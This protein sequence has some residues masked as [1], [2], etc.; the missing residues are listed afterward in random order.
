[1]QKA[2]KAHGYCKYEEEM[3][4]YLTYHS[5]ILKGHH[6]IKADGREKRTHKVWQERHDMSEQTNGDVKTQKPHRHLLT[7]TCNWQLSPRCALMWFLA[8]ACLYF[9]IPACLLGVTPTWTGSVV[10]G[11][12]VSALQTIFCLVKKLI[13][14]IL[15][16]KIEMQVPSTQSFIFCAGNTG[17][18]WR[19]LPAM[20]KKKSSRSEMLPFMWG[21]EFHRQL[22]WILTKFRRNSTKMLT[23]FGSQ[24]NQCD[25]ESRL[26]NQT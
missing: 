8:V 4:I 18:M 20:K 25:K 10:R 11:N 26:A 7:W 23:F 21:D 17:T 9:L 2:Q 3:S 12:H 22:Q 16:F 14:W 15:M 24:W 1:M 6:C 19:S 5:Q 13:W